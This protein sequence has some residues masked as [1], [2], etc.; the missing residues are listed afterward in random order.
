MNEW[1]KLSKERWMHVW[2][3]LWINRLMS[4]LINW[5]KNAKN[6]YMDEWMIVGTDERIGKCGE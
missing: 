5:M 1:K 6:G 3:E 4:E 2:N